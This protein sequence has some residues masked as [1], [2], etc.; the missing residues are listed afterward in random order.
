MISEYKPTCDICTY[1][2]I[3]WEEIPDGGINMLFDEPLKCK[4]H[5]KEVDDNHYC[6]DWVV[7]L[8]SVEGDC[9]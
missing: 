3:Q 8:K 9:E 1:S 7:D 2:F 4:L 6:C 5:E